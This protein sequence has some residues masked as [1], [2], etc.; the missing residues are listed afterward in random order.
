MNAAVFASVLLASRLPS[1]GHV[2][3][4][5]LLAFEVFAGFPMVARS[6]KLYSDKA[7]I[8]FT[9]VVI[10]ITFFA[11]LNALLT[12]AIVYA[13]SVFF[14]AVISPLWLK[15]IQRYKKYTHIIHSFPQASCNLLTLL[16]NV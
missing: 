2:F 1:S 10:L 15:W 5:M 12:L 9:S 14:I 3:A 11:L 4:I 8:Y 13:L 6:I 7:H 16:F